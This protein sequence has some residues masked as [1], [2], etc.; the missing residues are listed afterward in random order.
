MKRITLI[1]L[2]IFS[3]LSCEKDKFDLNNP[4]VEQ[5]VQ[6]LKN[7]TYIQYEKGENGENLWLLMPKFTKNHIQSLIDFSKDTS[8]INNFPINPISSRTPFPNDRDYFILGECLLWTVEGIRNGNGFGSLDPY[9]ID[10]TSGEVHKGLKG[11][12][13]LIVRDSF[14]VWWSNFKD[15]DWQEKNPLDGTPYRWF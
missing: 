9:L 15:T 4:N 2:L 5:F 3:I 11:I 14:Q 7:G 13:I 6:Q 8:H 10:I 1:A 12:G